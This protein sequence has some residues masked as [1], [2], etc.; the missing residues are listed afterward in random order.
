MFVEKGI[1]LTDLSLTGIIL[2]EKGIAVTDLR[3]M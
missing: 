3:Q 1:A 2:V